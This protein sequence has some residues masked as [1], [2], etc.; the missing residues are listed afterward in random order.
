MNENKRGRDAIRTNYGR[1][2]LGRNQNIELSMALIRNWSKLF[3]RNSK[4]MKYTG[5][6]QCVYK[7]HNENP[8]RQMTF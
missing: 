2:A 4:I 3:I 6:N 5:W 1:N 8:I 7:I